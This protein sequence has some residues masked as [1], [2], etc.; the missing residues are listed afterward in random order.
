MDINKTALH[1]AWGA[2]IYGGYLLLLLIMAGCTRH[3]YVVNRSVQLTTPDIVKEN[4]SRLV[5]ITQPAEN[6]TFTSGEQFLFLV[7]PGQPF[8]ESELNF[9]HLSGAELISSPTSIDQAYRFATLVN[10]LVSPNTNYWPNNSLE[11][12]PAVTRQTFSPLTSAHYDADFFLTIINPEWDTVNW[13]NIEDIG[14]YVDSVRI[15][16]SYIKYSAPVYSLTGEVKV[17]NIQRPWID[18]SF[19]GEC[20]SG[21]RAGKAIG[22]INRIVLARNLCIKAYSGSMINISIK[23]HNITEV[24]Y[25]QPTATMETTGVVIIA[26]ACVAL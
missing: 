5:N 10:R 16:H 17:L 26:Y 8:K 3:Y 18:T 25:D 14:N 20:I 22:Y 1:I 11:N 15:K 21:T 4:I 6:S 2:V 12:C 13:T 24:R 7:M 23:S 9:T 19:L